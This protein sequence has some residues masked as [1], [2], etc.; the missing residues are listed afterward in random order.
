MK[1]QEFTLIE[2]LVACHPKPWRRTTRWAF[3]LIELLVVIAIIAVLAALLLPALEKARKQAR[4]VACAANLKQ[5]GGGFTMYG[6]DY[7]R[8]PPNY[9]ASPHLYNCHL[10]YCDSSVWGWCMCPETGRYCWN[11]MGL[12]HGYVANIPR[13]VYCYDSGK[14]PVLFSPDK[15]D[16]DD[17]PWGVQSETQNGPYSYQCVTFGGGGG[18]MLVNEWPNVP[19]D[20]PSNYDPFR[21]ACPHYPLGRHKLYVNACVVFESDYEPYAALGLPDWYFLDLDPL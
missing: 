6:T 1:K 11:I 19:I 16:E 13:N 17:Y 3:T 14:A 18:Q 8:Y 15:A 12:A 2:L 10:Y 4:I 20:H 7:Q 9:C 5:L 21:Y